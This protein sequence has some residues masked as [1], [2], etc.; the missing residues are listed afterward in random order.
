MLKASLLLFL[1]WIPLLIFNVCIDPYGVFFN[2]SKHVP[3]EPNRRYMKMKYIL[4]NPEKF[5]S[6]IFGSSRTN[7]LN[8]DKIPTDSYYNM[9]YAVGLP[10]DYYHDL[11]LMS[12]SGIK[13]K[14][15]IIGIDDISLIENPKVPP[16]DLI[17]KT[18][19]VSLI[20]KISFFKSYILYRPSWLF[21]DMVF[22]SNDVSDRRQIFRNGMVSKPELDSTILRSPSEHISPKRF[23]KPF[24]R[25]RISP[26]VTQSISEIEKIIMFAKANQINLIFY[27]NPI[28]QVTYLNVNLDKYF[29]ALKKLADITSFYDFSGLNSIAINN[30]DYYEASHFNEKVG[31]LILAKIFNQDGFA[32]PDDFGRFVNKDNV[33]QQ[34]L[35]HKSLIADYYKSLAIQ[36]SYQPPLDLSQFKKIIKTP[37]T[38]LETINGVEKSYLD[39]TL[40]ITTP[41]LKIAGNIMPGNPENL[42]PR[43]M[44]QIGERLFKANVDQSLKGKEN[45]SSNKNTIDSGWDFFV[46]ASML[47]VGKQ[48]LKIITLSDD[49]Q[50]YSVSETNITFNIFHYIEPIEEDK[51][52]QLDQTDKLAVDEI[53][54]ENAANFTNLSPCTFINLS[55][56]AIDPINNTESGGVIVSLDGKQYRSQI[57]WERPELSLHFNNKALDFSGWGIT[58]PCA[59]IQEGK[60]ELSFKMLNYDDTGFYPAKN[61][62]FFNYRKNAYDSLT[63]LNRLESSTKYAVDVIN[64]KV[65]SS[66]K[67]PIIISGSKISILGWA[68]DFPAATVASKV[69]V[70]INNK[71]YPCSY[72]INR[73]DVAKFFN[74][75]ELEN[76]GWR[77]DIPTNNVGK[78]KFILTLIIVSKSGLSYYEADRK[79]TIEIK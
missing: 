11:L 50:S 34:I 67:Q 21:V 62:I 69:M 60:H 79:I 31:D 28:Y 68:I 19:P 40:I 22:K 75:N 25:Y 17:F 52:V 39:D 3:V 8:P 14:N 42:P 49:N 26:D 1:V 7:S 53:N 35:F 54:G 66:A 41:W 65:V 56:W 74:N 18:Y 44:V 5:D 6:F 72:G 58:I 38:S 64:G 63:G 43:I 15:L 77:I 47:S 76:C 51:L 23:F 24:S 33:E 27:I 61:N 73:P 36:H 59:D 48:P 32:V 20:D 10:K 46:P 57:I 2:C 78:G 70:E 37:V 9:S 4:K 30:M 16:Q 71:L 45:N 55:G 13:I 29:Y 12:K